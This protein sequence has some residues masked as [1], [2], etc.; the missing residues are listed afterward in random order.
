MLLRILGWTA[1][2]A[3]AVVSVPA[4]AE[5]TG[6]TASV[7]T[8]VT[9]PAMETAAPAIALDQHYDASVIEDL[10]ASHLAT[11]ESVVGH[12]ETVHAH[13]YATL[14]EVEEMFEEP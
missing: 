6:C 2:A 9:W 3:L 8:D 11:D 5:E 1:A 12:E 10:V 7:C 4:L 14:D 13:Q